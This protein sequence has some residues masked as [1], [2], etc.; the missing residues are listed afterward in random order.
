[1]RIGF[2]YLMVRLIERSDDFPEIERL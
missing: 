2:Q 1:M